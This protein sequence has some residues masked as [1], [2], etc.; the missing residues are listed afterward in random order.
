MMAGSYAPLMSS[1]NGLIFPPATTMELEVCPLRM[2][3]RKSK[4]GGTATCSK[5]RPP[6]FRKMLPRTICHGYSNAAR[7]NRQCD[8]PTGIDRGAGAISL[9]G[10]DSNVLPSWK[11]KMRIKIRNSAGDSDGPEPCACNRGK[12][13][14]T[15]I[16]LLVVIAI[17]AILAAMLLP[18]LSKAKDRAK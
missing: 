2:A 12:P 16:E 17:I 11:Q 5:P 8:A 1:R 18:A 4:N 14:F 10:G 9:D 15:L 6:T 3:M 13:G 7:P